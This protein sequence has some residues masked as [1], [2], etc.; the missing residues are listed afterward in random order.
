MEYQA[1]ALWQRTLA[2]QGD[3]DPNEKYREKLRSSFMQFREH[4]EPLAREIALSVPNYTDHSIQHCDSLWETASLVV[5]DDLPLNPA[6]AFVLGGAFLVHDLGMGAAAYSQG[7]PILFESPEWLDHLARVHPDDFVALHE[8]AILDAAKDPTWNGQTRPE[9]K[10][11]LTTYLRQH[12]ASHAA[13]ILK[14]EWRLG[15]GETF[16][17]LADTRLRLAFG[18]LIG[19]VGRSHWCDVDQLPGMFKGLIGALAGFPPDWTIDALKVA[20]I[21]RTAD[22]AHIDA[23]RA[24]PLHTPHRRPQGESADHWAFQQRMLSPQID[25]GRLLYTTGAPFD[26]EHADAWWLAFDTANMIDDEL[27]KV[28]ALLADSRKPR[29]AA[30]GVA[31]AQN[32]A[33]FAELI[34]TTGWTPIDARPRI[35]DSDKIIK[36]L[37]GTALYGV[38]SAVVPLR[39]LLANAVDATRA[40]RA[41]SRREPQPIEVV[42]SRGP[43]ADALE[44]RDFGIGMSDEDMANCLLDFGNS[45]WLSSQFANR[46]PGAIASG[47]FQPTGQFGIGFFSSFIV[48]DD[49]VVH[50]RPLWAGWEDSFVLE[51]RGGA[52]GRPILRRARPA[53]RLDEP[54]TIVRLTLRERADRASGLLGFAGHLA[55]DGGH[56]RS[57]VRRMA[58]MANEPIMVQG[59]EEASSIIAVGDEPWQ[60]IDAGQIYDGLTYESPSLQVS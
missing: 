3:E 50:S 37:G 55:R 29:F 12:H 31:G 34:P 26:V 36:S 5:G 2:A 49:V 4:V 24:D 38:R 44:V 18:D 59:M 51:F 47:R 22:A 58:L 1:S 15:N 11:A 57:I 39:E 53:E 60:S 42:L 32:T 23:R 19:Q 30:R 45:G 40:R 16:H 21:L 56:F 13:E 35:G 9:V 7:L 46:Y 28:D 8:T 27:R 33:R 43:E 14:H 6:E 41:I 54:G 48:A 10:S 17:L 25:D 52:T 20:C